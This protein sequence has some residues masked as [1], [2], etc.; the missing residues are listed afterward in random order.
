MADLAELRAEL[1][2]EL[3]AEQRAELAELRAELR[4]HVQELITPCRAVDAPANSQAARAHVTAQK[5]TK[6]PKLRIGQG[7]SSVDK[8]EADEHVGSGRAQ[9]R[10]VLENVKGF[11]HGGRELSDDEFVGPLSDSECAGSHVEHKES[12]WRIAWLELQSEGQPLLFEGED[13]LRALQAALALA[14]Q[15]V[16]EEWCRRP[17]GLK[18]RFQGF[19]EPGVIAKIRAAHTLVHKKAQ[20]IQLRKAGA[21]HA[22]KKFW[23]GRGEGGSQVSPDSVAEDFMNQ[24]DHLPALSFP[25]AS[26][27]VT[28]RHGLCSIRMLLAH[29]SSVNTYMMTR[30]VNLGLT[31]RSYVQSGH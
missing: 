29:H 14:Q 28:L 27:L 15:K 16:R 30:V 8:P 4:A 23:N 26:P 11:L 22:F 6:S 20:D 9:V 19:S 24:Y 1:L 25:H 3:R 31:A 13:D 12:D 21:L 18:A 2:A 17:D 7:F 10:H 5:R